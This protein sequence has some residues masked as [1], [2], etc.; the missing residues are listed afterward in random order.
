MRDVMITQK[1]MEI[2][3]ALNAFSDEVSTIETRNDLSEFTEIRIILDRFIEKMKKSEI[4]DSDLREV[5][6][7]FSHMLSSRG[8]RL[9]RETEAMTNGIQAREKDIEHMSVEELKVFNTELARVSDRSQLFMAMIRNSVSMRRLV[10]LDLDT[11]RQGIPR[12]ILNTPISDLASGNWQ[13]ESDFAKEGKISAADDDSDLWDNDAAYAC[14]RSGA[15]LLESMIGVQPEF[16][17]LLRP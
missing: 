11:V 2:I 10:G 4:N 16:D 17:V 15:E 9:L 8:E 7:A 1:R 12:E 6:E 14:S 3:D 13:G 5:V